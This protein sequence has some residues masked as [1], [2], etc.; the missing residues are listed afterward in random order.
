MRGLYVHVNSHRS[1]PRARASVCPLLR[2][3]GVERL[4]LHGTTASRNIRFF[5]DCSIIATEQL[6]GQTANSSY[7]FNERCVTLTPAFSSPTVDVY[8][9]MSDISP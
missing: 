9:H 3:P 2:R 6:Q 5:I 4:D 8:R 7:G 1:H